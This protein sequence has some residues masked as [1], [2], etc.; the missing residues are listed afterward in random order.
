MR[1]RLLVILFSWGVYLMNGK[2][3]A[4]NLDIEQ[5]SLDS[6]LNISINSA[7]R[8]DQKTSEAPASITLLTAED[9]SRYGYQSLAE[10]LN[11]VRGIYLTN[12]RNYEYVGMRGFSRPTDYN[13]RILLMIDGHTMNDNLEGGAPLGVKLY[14]LDLDH[15]ERVEI[16]RGP[17]SSL[18]GNYPMMGII[19]IVTKKGKDIQGADVTAQYGSY[20]RM[21]GSVSAGSRA[22]KTDWSVSG[23]V[24]QT[25]GQNLYFPE[26][27]DSSSNFGI[28]DHRDGKQFYSG[29]ARLS[30]GGFGIRA[31]LFGRRSDV[32]NGFYETL[33]ND[34]RSYSADQHAFVDASYEGKVRRNL[35]LRGRG[36]GH[37]YQF[38]GGYPYDRSEGG[39]WYDI[40]R[41]IWAGAEGLATWDMFSNNRVVGGLEVQRNFSSFYESGD[42]DTVY[43]KGNFPFTTA[44]VFMQ[45]EYQLGEKLNL[46]VGGRYDYNPRTKTRITPRAAVVWM[47]HKNTS[48]K[49]IYG[50]AYRAPN[51]NELY[52]ED[53]YLY[54]SNPNLKPERMRNLDLVFEQRIK[55]NLKFT[56]NLFDY[57]MLDLLDQVQDPVDS[58]YRF[59]NVGT[60]GGAGAEGELEMRLKG[61]IAGF[62]NYS[63]QKIRNIS[64]DADLTNSPCHI[65]KVSLSIPF[66]KH[67]RISPEGRFETSRLTVNDTETP[68]F[69]LLNAT[70]L[71][72]PVLNHEGGKGKFLERFT[73]S[74]KAYNILNTTYYHP[75]SIELIPDQFQ[76]DGR[77]FVV[78]LQV[79]I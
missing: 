9:I 7:S 65:G 71:F 5:I 56:L 69:A 31:G 44:S 73:L 51:T 23:Q 16:V 36:F 59:F 3:F 53:G 76:Q 27:D 17:A 30:S 68:A 54:A 12:D 78:R 29:T 6:L 15:V 55:Q 24:G 22:G 60:A 70:L 34:P 8:Y 43:F 38:T 14:G 45:D 77:N 10:L 19:N 2:A 64:E 47:P 49:A 46:V 75:G 26:Y 63:F 74:A 41:S 61:G 25:T 20:G 39:L 50:S 11:S 42:E 48:V 62:A 35:T 33:F 1:L 4:Q 79:K 66:L 52:G 21:Q 57:R 72:H 18:Y 28:S 37:Y 67:F 13:N 40:G 32:P 58:L